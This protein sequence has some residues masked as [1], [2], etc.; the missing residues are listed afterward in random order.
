M[1]STMIEVKLAVE[2]SKKDLKTWPYGTEFHNLGPSM[3][4]APYVS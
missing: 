1:A 3:Y 2:E 4:V